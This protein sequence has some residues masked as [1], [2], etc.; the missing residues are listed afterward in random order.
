MKKNEWDNKNENF[1]K[2]IQR[3]DNTISKRSKLLQL[4]KSK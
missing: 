3:V 2:A 1:E 4:Q